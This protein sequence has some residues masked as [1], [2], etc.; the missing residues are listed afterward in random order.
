MNL[1]KYIQ[2][3]NNQLRLTADKEVI[4]GVS[5]GVDSMVLLFLMYKLNY[6]IKAVHINHNTRGQENIEE[7]NIVSQFCLKHNIPLDIYN[8]YLK[9]NQNLELEARN[10]RYK[11]FKNYNKAILTAHH[12]DDSFEWHL[13]Q[14]FKSSS[15]NY[16]GIPARNKNIYR[17]LMCLTKK[18]I[19]RIA[20]KENIPYCEDTSNN[21][22]DH[23]RNYIRN[24]LIPFIEDRYPK[25]LKHYVNRM[26]NLT[27]EKGI[28]IT[29]KKVSDKK[30]NSKLKLNASYSEIEKAIKE[31]SKKSRGKIANNL[32]ALIKAINKGKRNFHMNFSGNVIV[33]VTK[34]EILVKNSKN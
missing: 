20:K 27:K 22:I 21:S 24:I 4:I 6:K 18:Q 8:F 12:I 15:N 5:G 25:Y 14:Q 9:K 28:H 29:S 31:K 26:N 1:L 13:M 17:P 3:F 33:E 10:F 30:I 16:Y 23:E 2:E 11:V 19:Y 32:N 34:N 7:Q